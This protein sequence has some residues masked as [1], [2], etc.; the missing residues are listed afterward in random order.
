MQHRDLS[1]D[2]LVGA[3]LPARLDSADDAVRGSVA[4]GLEQF[5][6]HGARARNTLLGW[7][8]LVLIA[9][10]NAFREHMIPSD[11]AELDRTSSWGPFLIARCARS[12]VPFSSL[13]ALA[14]S[15][16]FSTLAAH[17]PRNARRAG[18]RAGHEPTRTTSPHPRATL[19]ARATG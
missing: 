16:P 14:P 12:S 9:S 1:F 8:K 18:A 19:A 6:E 11:P 10:A 7:L 17:A 15:V 13:A 4:E 2:A 3:A 5:V